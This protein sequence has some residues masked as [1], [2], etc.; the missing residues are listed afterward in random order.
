ME[1]G[2]TDLPN[3]LV[4][5]DSWRKTIDTKDRDWGKF[6]KEVGK[7][8]LKAGVPGIVYS[9]AKGSVPK[10]R[11]YFVN[12]AIKKYLCKGCKKENKNF[13]D[14]ME[15]NVYPKPAA[16]PV[17]EICFKNETYER[18]FKYFNKEP[19]LAVIEVR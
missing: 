15:I 18:Y 1:C 12:L 6:L 19:Y 9:A 5:H 11:T 16:N 8:Y 10:T 13:E 14:L 3:L 2:S 7:S 4:K 17:Y